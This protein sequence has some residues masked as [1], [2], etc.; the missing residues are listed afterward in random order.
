MN[1]A[2]QVCTNVHAPYHFGHDTDRC[3]ASRLAGLSARAA[4]CLVRHGILG[5]RAPS[6]LPWMAV[7]VAVFLVFCLKTANLHIFTKKIL[8]NL[9][10]K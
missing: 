3:H 9:T 1:T 6:I 10:I 2:V 5:V 4:D 8:A 7:S